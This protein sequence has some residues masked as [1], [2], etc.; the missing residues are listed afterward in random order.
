MKSEAEFEDLKAAWLALGERLEEQE[1]AL[2]PAHVKNRRVRSVVGHLRPL[3]LGQVIQ[4]VMAVALMVWSAVFWVEHRSEVH[5]LLVG[6]ILQAYGVVVL[7][8]GARTLALVKSIDY[9]VPV[10]DIDATFARLRQWYRRS[11]MVVGLPWWLLWIPF[12]SMLFMSLFGVDML[13]ESP[14]VVWLGTSIGVVGLA[15]TWG[16]HRWAHHPNRPHLARRMSD[17]TAGASIVR[18]QVIIDEFAADEDGLEG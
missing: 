9:T 3:V 4:T 11:G 16:F 14:S 13:S 17:S 12:M 6:V 10:V 8:A 1:A 18:A 2:G 5:L 7:V 15:A